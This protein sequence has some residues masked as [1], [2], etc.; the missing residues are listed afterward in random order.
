MNLPSYISLCNAMVLLMKPLV[1]IVIHDLA[2][3][4]IS[5]I[6]GDLS[7]RKVGDLSLLDLTKLEADLDKIVYPKLNF[8]GRLIKSISVPLEAPW[9]VCINCDVSVFSQMHSLSQ[10]FLKVGHTAG[11][12]SIF[13]NDWQD[14]LHVAVHTFLEGK[15]WCFENLTSSQK[16]E[17]AKHLFTAGAFNE[18]NAADYVAS[19]LNMGR[20]TIF[21]F[22]KEWKKNAN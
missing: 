13:K 6:A 17:V 18:K 5:Y 16:K 4:T 22:L 3:G 11:P 8:D 21:K 20:A 15:N 12:E 9:L 14:K 10:L 7:K 1:E 2:S 19:T